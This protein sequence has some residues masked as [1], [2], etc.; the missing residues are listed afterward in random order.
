[1]DNQ[2]KSPL[3]PA[4]IGRMITK[5]LLIFFLIFLLY[6]LGVFIYR[7]IVIRPAQKAVVVVRFL[8]ELV[9]LAVPSVLFLDLFKG[10]VKKIK[11]KAARVAARIVKY[12]FMA[13]CFLLVIV[14]FCVADSVPEDTEMEVDYVFVLGLALEDGRASADLIKRVEKAIEFEKDHPNA[15]FIFSGGNAEDVENTEAVAMM[16]YFIDNGGNFE[17]AWGEAEAT[18]TVANFKNLEKMTGKDV[19]V[20]VI[21][22]DYHMLRAAGIMKNQGW[23]KVRYVPADSDTLL[24]NENCL[25]ESIC[26]IFGLAR[27][28]FSIV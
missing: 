22:S 14:M 13:F 25:W 1:M 20:A 18:D 10:L 2:S 21:T 12:I 3:T 8:S 27:G 16:T 5:T 9:V 23:E 15:V 4:Q 28:T 6:L 26:L 17:Y 19:P 7:I 24:Y 11:H